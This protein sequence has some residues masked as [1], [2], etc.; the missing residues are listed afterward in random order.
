MQR[1]ST[2]RVAS[3]VWIK[4]PLASV[5]NLCGMRQESLGNDNEE[6]KIKMKGIIYQ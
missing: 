1:R 6:Q 2:N 3:E 5:G 4:A